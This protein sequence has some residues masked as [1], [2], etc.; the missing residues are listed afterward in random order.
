M[1]Q[2]RNGVQLGFGAGVDVGLV[3]CG[4]GAGCVPG[5]VLGPVG[6]GGGVADGRAEVGGGAGVAVGGGAVDEVALPDA[7]GWAPADDG[8][9]RAVPETGAVA[10]VAVM[11]EA[12]ADSRACDGEP[13]E[14]G[15]TTLPDGAGAASPPAW[16]TA[17][18]AVASPPA[19]APTADRATTAPRRPVPR[20]LVFR[21]PRLRL[22]DRLAG[23]AGAASLGCRGSVRRSSC[24][25]SSFSGSAAEGPA[26]R[27]QPGQDSAP[28]RWRWQGVQ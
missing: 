9:G 1:H 14:A 21:R 5:P 16:P 2:N 7:L 13:G 25:R 20:R 10:R 23:V 17:S 22:V 19:T 26:A 8:C 24:P 6:L 18:K 3:G 12:L 28:L 15:A 4:V 11:A 27:P